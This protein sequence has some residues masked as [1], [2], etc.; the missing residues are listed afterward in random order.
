[1]AHGTWQ[2]AHDHRRRLGALVLVATEDFPSNS[3]DSP[4]KSQTVYTFV[5]DS[6]T[7]KGFILL[8]IQ[9]FEFNHLII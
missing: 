4:G 9:F 5:T 6:L 7:E 2:M 8:F 3:S 1:M